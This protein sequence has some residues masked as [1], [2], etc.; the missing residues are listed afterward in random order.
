M[1]THAAYHF[2]SS[3]QRVIYMCALQLWSKKNMVSVMTLST[4]APT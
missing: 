3:L 1:L 2:N 4:H